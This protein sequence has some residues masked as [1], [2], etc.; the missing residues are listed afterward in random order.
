MRKVVID[1]VVEP[2]ASR[3]LLA[4]RDRVFVTMGMPKP[5][6]PDGME[7]FYCPYSI[8]FRG[9]KKVRYAGGAD[10]VQALQLAMNMIGADLGLLARQQN[11]RI[12]W[13]DERLGTGFPSN[14][15]DAEPTRG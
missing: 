13:D 2:I 11:I 3:E 15:L 10:A 8:E 5:F 14:P 4:G 7:G 9:Q 12:F 1:G 6:D